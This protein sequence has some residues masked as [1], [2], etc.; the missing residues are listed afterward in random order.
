VKATPTI[1]PLCHPLSISGVE[2][3]FALDFSRTARRKAHCQWLAIEYQCQRPL[4]RRA[5]TKRLR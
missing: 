5:V 1:L 2:V 4:A 3:E